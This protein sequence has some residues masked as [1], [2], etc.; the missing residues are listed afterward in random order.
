MSEKYMIE[1]RQ[2]S[3]KFGRRGLF[4]LGRKRLQ[5]YVLSDVNFKV[6]EGE[7]FVLVGKNASGKT[8]LMR[9][10]TTLLLPTQGE[11]FVGGYNIITQARQ[12]RQIIGFASGQERDF[13]WRLSG[14][15]NLLFFSALYNLFNGHASKR[16]SVLAELLEIGQY[17]DLPFNQYSAGVRQRYS[18]ARSL[19][20]EPKIIFLDEPTKNLDDVI[21]QRIRGFICEKLIKE[22]G[23]TVF[24]TSP[25]NEEGLLFSDKIAVLDNGVVKS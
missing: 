1:A 7:L 8:T 15:K 9:I 22:E 24:I 2:L 25:S 19:L 12:V 23:R 11:A 13:D 17:L 14:R 5:N 6:R 4:S 16:I 18:I 21:A 10:L 3:K 20:S